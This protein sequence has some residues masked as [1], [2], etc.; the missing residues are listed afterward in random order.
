[1]R[2]FCYLLLGILVLL[3]LIG[4]NAVT[5]VE[6]LGTAPLEIE[7]AD[8][9]G[10]WTSHAAESDEGIV[11]S[12]EVVD[13]ADG[14]IRAV[15]LEN[16]EPHATR[17]YLRSAGDWTFASVPV[18]N[19]DYAFDRDEAPDASGA[20]GY[21]W[22]RIRKQGEAIFIW[23]PDVSGFRSLVE[24]GGLPGRIANPEAQYSEFLASD[25][26]GVP[27]EWDR[28]LVLVRSR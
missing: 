11:G 10:Y 8:W 27:F 6:P 20:S 19:D 5:V 16:G 28:P 26:A 4:C 24:D 23:L 25:A 22:A 3:P 15:W 14:I 18:S 2:D 7:P 13:A 1:M 21:V 9:E 17:I 12:I